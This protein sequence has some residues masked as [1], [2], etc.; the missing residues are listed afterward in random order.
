MADESPQKPDATRHETR[1]ID[2]RAVAWFGLG[3][4]I[5]FLL[6]F[7]MA[8]WLL[9]I[10]GAQHST[11][12]AVTQISGQQMQPPQPQLQTNSA[13]DMARFREWENGILTNYIWVDRPAGVVQIPIERAMDI[14]AERGLPVQQF[15]S[16]KT[17]LQMRQEK[18]N[19]EKP[20]P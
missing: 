20:S 8:R 4:V 10:F 9:G 6:I 19:A 16:G 12:A 3:L 13:A 14:I 17:P 2:A 7:L 15:S 5:T 1:D 18:A 11:G